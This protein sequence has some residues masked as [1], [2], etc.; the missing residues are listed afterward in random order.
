MKFAL[1]TNDSKDREHLVT[2]KIIDYIL[3]KGHSY[4]M[5]T[6]G[7]FCDE[8]YLD[9]MPEDIDFILSLGGDGTLLQ[10]ARKVQRRSLPILG[11]NLGTLGFLTAAEKGAF[12]PCLDQLMRG[13]YTVERRMMLRGSVGKK[14][15]PDQ[16]SHEVALNDIV[17]ARAGFSR[18]VELKIYVNDELLTIYGADG[19]IVSTPTGSTGYNLSAGGPIVFP[20]TDVMIITPI[21]P[22]SLQARSIVVSGDDKVRIEIG[23]RRKSQREEALVTFDGD[24]AFDLESGDMVEIEKA[25]ETTD[26]IRPREKGFYQ[27]LQSKIG[28]V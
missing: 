10:T 25:E 13:D 3:A 19:V 20:L 2:Q 4:W 7:A 16:D 1:I 22:H 12:E 6:G 17:I 26:L 24:T 27:I 21:C 11:I 18:L 14:R 28:G 5:P 15:F 9:D 8:C 23:R